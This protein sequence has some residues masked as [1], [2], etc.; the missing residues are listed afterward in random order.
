MKRWKKVRLA[1]WLCFLGVFVVAFLES[2]AKYA[3]ATALFIAFP[4]LEIWS[5]AAE[6][7]DPDEQKKREEQKAAKAKLREEKSREWAIKM[8]KEREDHTPVAAV[9]VTAQD[10]LSTS[11]GL[12]GAVVGGLIAGPVGAVVGA[13]AG[14]KTEV[15][16][17]KVT[18]SV[19]YASGR[20]GIET[21]DVKSKRFKELSALLVK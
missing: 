18:F 15:T 20:T 1:G 3:L 14:K 8:K 4:C 19:K 12:G 2:E 16:G 7:K 17:Q 10:K 9:V 11:G 6:R 5:I 21:V 13:S